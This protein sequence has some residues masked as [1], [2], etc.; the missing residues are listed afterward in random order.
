ML[1]AALVSCIVDMQIPHSD[2][3]ALMTVHF[4]LTIDR[5]GK[6]GLEMTEVKVNQDI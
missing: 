5:N 4:P 3:Q 6:E 2:F 1:R